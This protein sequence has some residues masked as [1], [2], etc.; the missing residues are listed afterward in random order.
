MHDREAETGAF[1][2][3]AA[4]RLKDCIQLVGGNADAFVADS[5]MTEF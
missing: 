4:E 2:E 5:S 3:R 1:R